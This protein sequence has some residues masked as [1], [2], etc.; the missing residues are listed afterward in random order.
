[1]KDRRTQREERGFLG[2][3]RTGSFC[4]MHLFRFSPRTFGIT[5]QQSVGKETIP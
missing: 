1:M 3:S 5:W 2:L 4:G